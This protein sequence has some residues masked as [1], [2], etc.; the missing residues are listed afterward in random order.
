MTLFV[1]KQRIFGESDIMKQY[2]G[3]FLMS[4]K[5]RDV[6]AQVWSEDLRLGPTNV[7]RCDRRRRKDLQGPDMSGGLET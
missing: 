7:G 2:H 3:S 4:S 6:T 1:Y 5:F